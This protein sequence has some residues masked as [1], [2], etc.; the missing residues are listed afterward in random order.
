MNAF[1]SFVKVGMSCSMAS[2]ES[3]DF[4]NVFIAESKKA[5]QVKDAHRR[6]TL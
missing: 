3:I 2:Q 6:S 1:S 5:Q 4:H